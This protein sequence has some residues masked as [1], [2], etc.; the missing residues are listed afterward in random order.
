MRRYIVPSIPHPHELAKAVREGRRREFASF[1]QR[2]DPDYLAGI[3][4]P[5]RPS[6]FERSRPVPDPSLGTRREELYKHLLA[7]RQTE[8]VPRLYRTQ[9][10]DARAVGPATVIAQWQM[11]DNSLLVIGT[12]LG[13]SAVAIPQPKGR[14]LFANSKNAGQVAQDGTLEPY[15]TIAFLK[16]R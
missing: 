15:C 4:D 1:S 5:N 11:G 10:L 16:T 12:N 9:A 6:T 7:I 3:P 13:K 2:A 8:I 14:L